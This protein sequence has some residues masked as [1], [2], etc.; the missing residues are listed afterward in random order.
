MLEGLKKFAMAVLALA[1]SG[2]A[3]AEPARMA[4]L[5][6][7]SD[8]NGDGVIDTSPE[9]RQQAISEG[10]APDLRNPVN[11][12]TDVG[13]AL[14][15]AGFDTLVVTDVSRSELEEVVASFAQRAN[16]TAGPDA[17]VCSTSQDTGVQNDGA[18]FLVPARARMPRRQPSPPSMADDD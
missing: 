14:A 6:G 3:S 18:D 16:T 11:D 1:A 10:F 13:A 7:I 17:V 5:V 9:A 15:R 12:V 4:L 2:A 8:Y